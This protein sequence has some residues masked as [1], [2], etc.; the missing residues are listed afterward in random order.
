M[1]MYVYIVLVWTIHFTMGTIDTQRLYMMHFLIAMWV[2]VGQFASSNWLIT[3]V[4][5]II[6]ILG[7]TV[8]VIVLKEYYGDYQNINQSLTTFVFLIFCIELAIYLNERAKAD[9]FVKSKQV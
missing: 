1:S 6:G 5:R 7:N 9:L 4:P 3:A 2:L 8:S